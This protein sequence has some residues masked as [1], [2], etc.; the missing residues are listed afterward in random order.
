MN[1]TDFSFAS[2]SSLQFGV[3]KFLTLPALI[4]PLTKNVLIVLGSQSHKTSEYI[5]TVIGKLEARFSVTIITIPTEPTPE[6]VDTAVL[7]SQP[8]V[9]DI[10]V[11]VGGGSVLDAGKAISAMIPVNDGVKNYLEGVGT[12]TH[13]GTKIPF[14]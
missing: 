6:M 3:G 12:K 13:P 5:T 4:N 14:I 1:Y 11:A 7:Q 10:V 8:N 9:P 2:P